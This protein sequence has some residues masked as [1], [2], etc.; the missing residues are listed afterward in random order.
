LRDL[1]R[2]AELRAAGQGLMAQVTGN[3][4][5]PPASGAER[6]RSNSAVV[7][8][9]RLRAASEMQRQGM[10]SKEEKALMK[11]LILQS[12]PMFREQFDRARKT[13]DLAAIK[14]LLK[15]NELIQDS[16]LSE[17]TDMTLGDV[18]D[19]SFLDD[20]AGDH[21]GNSAA[22]TYFSTSN[23]LNSEQGGSHATAKP[24][25]HGANNQQPS[26]QQ[27]RQ[28]VGFASE[29]GSSLIK[30]EPTDEAR[31][32]RQASLSMPQQG[33][34]KIAASVGTGQKDVH[35]ASAATGAINGS[36]TDTTNI[37]NIVQGAQWQPSVKM[38]SKPNSQNQPPIAYSVP[39]STIPVQAN[40][41]ST[42]S[43]TPSSASH[44][45]SDS[46]PDSEK[47]GEAKS[48]K[49]ERERKRR[50][51]V[52]QGFDELYK[53][54]KRMEQDRMALGLPP[55]PE[56]LGGKRSISSSS[57]LDKSSILQNAIQRITFLESQIA[58]LGRE[59]HSLSAMV[60]NNNANNS[61]R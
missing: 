61:R 60:N 31:R 5:V 14:K 34:N 42:F 52:T 39:S 24:P 23:N 38:E 53:L 7:M 36:R 16:M 47:V 27:P 54:L 13:N 48:R 1:E 45:T 19:L 49:N 37:K 20:F 26:Q 18:D 30:Q 43:R 9:G 51:Q 59:N 32:K 33:M 8:S 2:R 35:S 58:R 4:A 41:S 25:A 28:S 11:Q 12:D 15:S 57:K 22:T 44:L 29:F 6:G 10:I 56:P 46:G 55:A 40:F 3:V 21:G 17:L 50:L